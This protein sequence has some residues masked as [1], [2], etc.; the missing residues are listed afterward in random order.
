M[1]IMNNISRKDI[2]FGSD[3]NEI[4]VIKK[5]G[6]VVKIDKDTKRK[7]AGRIWDE[8]IKSIHDLG[9]F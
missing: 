9:N 6:G 2:G 7:I 5:D 4:S 1:I 8:I 3:F